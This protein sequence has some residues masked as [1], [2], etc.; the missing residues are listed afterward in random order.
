MSLC[1]SYIVLG[2]GCEKYKK[3]NI[4]YGNSR[5]Q[6]LTVFCVCVC[7]CM[8]FLIACGCVIYT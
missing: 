4:L 3:L 8:Q 1:M 6:F 5:F 7:S 2:S